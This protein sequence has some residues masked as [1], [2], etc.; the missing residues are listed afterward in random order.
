MPNMIILGEGGAVD[1]RRVV[2]V[3]PFRSKP[4]Q[5]LLHAAGQSKVLNMTYGYPRVS[6]ILMVNGFLIISSRTVEELTR[7]FHSEADVNHDQSPFWE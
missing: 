7:V 4:V 6:V 1:A 2:A 3:V 5:R